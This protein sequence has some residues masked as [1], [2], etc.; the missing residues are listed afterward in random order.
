MAVILFVG[1]LS[2]MA[3]ARYLER[4]FSAYGRVERAEVF[5]EG[6][7]RYAEVTFAEMDDADTAIA[8]L[9]YRYCSAKNVPLLVLYSRSSP[10]V[11]AYG[12][13]V[14]EEFLN[15]LERKRMP[16]PVPLDYFDT[17]YLRSSVILPPPDSAS[18]HP[19][20]HPSVCDSC[21]FHG[22]THRPPQTR[23]PAA[24]ARVTEIIKGLDL[25]A[26]LIC[27][28]ISIDTN[29]SCLAYSSFFFLLSSFFSRPTLPF[30]FILPNW[31]ASFEHQSIESPTALC[32][33]DTHTAHTAR[34]AI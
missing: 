31:C 2:C 18:L 27:F 3:N 30:S 20:T 16:D 12:R 21:G 13:R 1:N 10:L 28:G 24:E 33:S 6:N 25:Q 5:G 22:R 34:P 26:S 23:S 15:C 29:A 32:K 19:Q 7:E 9:H 17:Q 14:G 8:A 4:L 11:S